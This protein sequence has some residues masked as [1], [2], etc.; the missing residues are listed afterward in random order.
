MQMKVRKSEKQIPRDELTRKARVLRT[1]WR[2]EH[3]MFV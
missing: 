1:E 2:E 3:Y